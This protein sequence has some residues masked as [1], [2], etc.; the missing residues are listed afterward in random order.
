[1]P[2]TSSRTE[3]QEQLRAAQLEWLDR[4]L[5]S[6]GITPTEL[7]RKSELVH[8]TLTGFIAGKRNRLLSSE[9][10]NRIVA[11]TGFPPPVAPLAD[12]ARGFREE[13]ADPFRHQVGGAE[14]EEAI[15]ALVGCRE[16]ADAWVLRTRALELAGY[17]PGDIVVLDLGIEAKAGDVVCAQIYD[18]QRMRADTIWRIYEPPYLVAASADPALRKPHRDDAAAIKGVVVGLVRPRRVA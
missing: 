16:N 1:M 7:A 11:E 18:I 15:R 12:P 6:L 9:T 3:A 17:L 8:T 2:R 14:E 4:I 5:S 13:E 10:I